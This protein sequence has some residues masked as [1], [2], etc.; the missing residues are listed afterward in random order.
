[1]GWKRARYC[2]LG[3]KLKELE[4]P[5]RSGRCGAEVQPAGMT[6]PITGKRV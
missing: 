5:A 4:V 1:M 6:G 3:G 2:L